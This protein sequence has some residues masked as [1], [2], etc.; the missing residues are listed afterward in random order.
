MNDRPASPE[1]AQHISDR[2]FRVH[3]PGIDGEAGA[4]GR[5]A[6]FHLGEAEIV[7]DQVHQVG[8][9]LAVMD[10]ETGIDANLLGIFAQQPSADAME[11]AGPGQRVGHDAGPAAKH[12]RA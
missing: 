9:V 3:D 10:G 4:L 1:P 12:L 8:A 6:A 7:P 2:L 5:E 11:G